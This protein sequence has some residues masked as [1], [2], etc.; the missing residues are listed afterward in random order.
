MYGEFVAALNKTINLEGSPLN[1]FTVC[2]LWSVIV[3]LKLGFSTQFV[4]P[5]DVLTF[6][7]MPVVL[8]VDSP[9]CHSGLEASLSSIVYPSS[10]E[11]ATSKLPKEVPAEKWDTCAVPLP[12]VANKLNLLFHFSFLVI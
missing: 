6:L 7:T 10:P 4:K 3:P 9:N 1:L 12:S 8:T 2:H 5:V 11:N